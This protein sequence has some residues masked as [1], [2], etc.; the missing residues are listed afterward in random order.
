MK[1][2]RNFLQMLLIH[3]REARTKKSP[4]PRQRAGF[5]R[6]GSDQPGFRLFQIQFAAL[7]PAIV[8]GKTFAS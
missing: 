5:F 4:Y 6:F 3:T 2:F 7:R 1:N 8:G